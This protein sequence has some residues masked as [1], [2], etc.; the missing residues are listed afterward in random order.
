VEAAVVG[1]PDDV[2]GEKVGAV[3]V[4]ADDFDAELLLAHLED[5]LADFK[6]PQY[7]HLS[8][9]PLPRN[10]GGKLLKRDLR[11]TSTWQGPLW[12]R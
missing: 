2:M 10:P 9:R 12:G 4:A 6:I 11:T 7:L 5:H 1:V 3:I 8:E